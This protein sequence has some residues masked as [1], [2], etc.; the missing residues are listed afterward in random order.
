MRVYKYVLFLFVFEYY[1]YYNWSG[2]E[3]NEVL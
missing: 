3:E 1:L 2:G